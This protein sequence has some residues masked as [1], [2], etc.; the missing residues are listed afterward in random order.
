[1]AGNENTLVRG[2]PCPTCGAVMLWTQS[3]WTDAGAGS[4][5]ARAA[6]RCVNGHLI[7]P[8]QTP[9]CPACGIHDT[10][11]AESD[12]HRCRRCGFTFRAWSKS[13]PA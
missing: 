5:A 8:S 9:Q 11:K 10:A 6:Y 12:R 2:E 7:D 13:D 1:M 3:V 4:M